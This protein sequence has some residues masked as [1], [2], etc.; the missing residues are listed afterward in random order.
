MINP[1]PYK[2]CSNETLAFIVE[3]STKEQQNRH[4]ARCKRNYEAAIAIEASCSH[5]EFAKVHWPDTK[6]GEPVE[7]Y[8]DK[9]PMKATLLIHESIGGDHCVAGDQ[10][11]DITSSENLTKEVFAWMMDNR[12]QRKFLRNVLY[13]GMLFEYT[14]KPT[15]T[16]VGTGIEI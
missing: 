6:K 8:G 7:H 16:E 9:K 13:D 5:Q 14:S 2:N 3:Q 12:L 10:A 11:I 4:A 1:A 15:L